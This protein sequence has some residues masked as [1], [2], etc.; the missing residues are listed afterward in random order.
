[1]NLAATQQ[2]VFGLTG[3]PAAAVVIAIALC[4]AAVAIA[5]FKLF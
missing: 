1:M 5:F 4:L 3:W 2:A